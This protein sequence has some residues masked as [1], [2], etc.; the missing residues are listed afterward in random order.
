LK[1]TDDAGAAP[2][3]RSNGG[4]QGDQARKFSQ[5]QFYG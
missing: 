2:S 5:A 3:V 1:T 4:A